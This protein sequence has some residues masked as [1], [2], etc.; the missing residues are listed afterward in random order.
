MHGTGPT[1]RPYYCRD[2]GALLMSDEDRKGPSGRQITDIGQARP[3]DWILLQIKGG[4]FQL[5][6]L[7][8]PGIG[9]AR[10]GLES[11]LGGC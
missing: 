10:A 1:S 9:L 7:E 8:R 4:G 11:G 2:M 3:D 5:H 6:Q